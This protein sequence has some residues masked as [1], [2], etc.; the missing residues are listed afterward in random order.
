[1]ASGLCALRERT[2][3]RQASQAPRSYRRR[4]N[5][6][7]RGV[8][9]PAHCVSRQWQGSTQGRHPRSRLVMGEEVHQHLGGRFLAKDQGF[10]HVG[11]QGAVL[12]LQQIEQA[13]AQSGGNAELQGPANGGAR[14]RLRPTQPHQH[15]VHL[16][17]CQQRM[18]CRGDACGVLCLEGRTQ[19]GIG[20]GGG[21]NHQ[22]VQVCEE[23]FL[24]FRGLY[25][26]EVRCHQGSLPLQPPESRLV[27]VLLQY[28]HQR[29]VAF[30]RVDFD[31][32]T[33][34]TVDTLGAR[35]HGCP[36]QEAAPAAQPGRGTS[37]QR[38]GSPSWL[39]MTRGAHLKGH[40]LI[41]EA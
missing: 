13:R 28:V 17:Q 5:A 21:S 19:H 40:G 35:L 14:F 2:A 38:R 16:A 20:C 27:Q 37:P 4:A 11:L 32:A 31:R 15:F 10:Q 33:L 23:A 25:Q 3:V 36:L 29:H 24:Q 9:Q 34:E 12:Q 6:G 7:V 39:W 18:G 22:P 8:Q 26:I 41:L 1:M 30:P